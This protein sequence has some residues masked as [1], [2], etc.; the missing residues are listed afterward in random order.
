[1]HSIAFPLSRRLTVGFLL[2]LT[3]AGSLSLAGCRK[4]E[5]SKSSEAASALTV[6]T[7]VVSSRSLALEIEVNGNVAAWDLLPVIPAANGL[8]IVQVLAEEGDA[9]KKGDLLVKLDDSILRAQVM[10]AKA[11][12]QS[13][14]A[15]LDKMKRP[16][17]PQELATAEAALAQSEASW[18]SSK[19]AYERAMKLKSAGGTTNAEIVTRQSSLEA[20]QA[21][22]EQAR[23]RLI[24]LREGSRL[25]DLA[26]GSA[27]VAEAKGGLAQAEAL[28]AQTEVRAPSNGYILKR[29]AHLG[30]MSSVAKTLYSMVRDS[31]L[32]VEALVPE[33]D[34]ARLAAGQTAVITSDALP[35]LQLKGRVRQLSPAIDT[36]NRL[37]KL[38]IDV[39]KA[40]GLQA[41][42]FV[43]AK[44]LLGQRK[45]LAV[46]A[47]AIVSREAGSEVFVLDGKNAR[48]RQVVLGNRS[49]GYVAVMDGL[50]A[51]EEIIVNGVGFLKDG[52]VVTIAPLL[53]NAENAAKTAEGK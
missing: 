21:A 33:A 5:A 23:Q 16:S 28:L 49:E 13:S 38:E 22:A 53:P 11:R 9:V 27:Q 12:L 51:G 2:G 47:S 14:L 10:Q 34:L 39:P 46:P 25:E 45:A 43:K 30:D 35:D 52:D 26:I 18:R 40:K 29:D 48:R 8:K 41:G 19:D 24:M 1:M 42:M 37:A 6:S 15:Q 31:R 3:M 32:E 17:R 44:V 20:S 36:T 4:P 7:E 50:Q